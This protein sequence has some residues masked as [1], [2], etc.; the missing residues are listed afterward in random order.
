MLAVEDEEGAGLA[1]AAGV[2][3]MPA[4]TAVVVAVKFA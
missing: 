3:T 2:A 1:G 4:A